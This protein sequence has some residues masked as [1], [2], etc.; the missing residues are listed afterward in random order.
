MSE[1]PSIADVVQES[2]KLQAV[3]K[4]LLETHFLLPGVFHPLAYI[5]DAEKIECSWERR[6]TRLNTVAMGVSLY[7][8]MFAERVRSLLNGHDATATDET[9]HALGVWEAQTTKRFP[10]EYDD[11]EYICRTLGQYLEFMNRKSQE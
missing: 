8:K 7:N 10:D 1:R 11:I 6:K 5:R 4:E 2:E 3:I 9:K